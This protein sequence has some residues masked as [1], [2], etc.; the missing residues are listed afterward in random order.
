VRILTGVVLKDNVTLGGECEISEFAVVGP[1]VQLG[2]RCRVETYASLHEDVVLGEACE[3]L[4]RAILRGPIRAGSSNQF[5]QFAMIGG[6]S[7][8]LNAARSGCIVIGSHCVF[9][10]SSVVLAPRGSDAGGLGSSAQPGTT[11]IGD[12]VFVHMR[13]EVSHDCVLEDHV[14]LAG[15]LTGFCHAMRGAKVMKGVQVHQFTT[16]GTSAFLT[17]GTRVRY[18]VLPY[19]VFDEKTMVLDRIALQRLGKSVSEA[20]DLQAFYEQNFS[21]DAAH[22]CQSVDEMFQASAGQ[23]GLWFASELRRFFALRAGMRDRRMLARFGSAHEPLAE[24][25]QATSPRRK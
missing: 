5:Q 4:E 1:N 24:G 7:T 19:C 12:H 15:E 3:V 20:D 18:D 21:S 25:Q 23:E 13:G 10:I 22:Y 9:E 8:H 17:M 14:D 6:H 2:P 16:I 11:R